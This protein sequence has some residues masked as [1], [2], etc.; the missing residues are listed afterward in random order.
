MTPRYDFTNRP[1]YT[2][3]LNCNAFAFFI[4]ELI[5]GHFIVNNK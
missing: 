4:S 5:V 1:L 2:R 3:V